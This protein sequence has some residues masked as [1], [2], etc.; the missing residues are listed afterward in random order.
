MSLLRA[1]PPQVHPERAPLSLD[2][3]GMSGRVEGLT[4][5]ELKRLQVLD[6]RA[7]VFVR[8]NERPHIVSAVAAPGPRGVEPVAVVA[9]AS[10]Q[11]AIAHRRELPIRDERLPAAGAIERPR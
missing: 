4:M 2:R 11:I 8:A 6:Q 10:Q 3:L 5:S 1:H 9:E 7:A